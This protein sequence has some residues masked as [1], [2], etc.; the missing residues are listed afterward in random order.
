MIRIRFSVAVGIGAMLG[1]VASLSLATIAPNMS[2][3]AAP[4]RPGDP[5]PQCQPAPVD[6]S[7][8][9]PAPSATP[10]ILVNP[11][12]TQVAPRGGE[13]GLTLAWE[14]A[15]A[16]LPHIRGIHTQVQ[17]LGNDGRWYDVAGWQRALTNSNRVQWGF[18]ATDAGRGPFRWLVSDLITRQPLAI[19]KVFMLPNGGNADSEMVI[20]R[21]DSKPDAS[22]AVPRTLVTAQSAA[23]M[24]EPNAGVSHNGILAPGVGLT[25]LGV[26]PSGTWL[27]VR[28]DK[29][30]GWLRLSETRPQ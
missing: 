23:L 27:N 16:L 8:P 20:G 13:I 9:T 22:V 30:S 17:W 25:V 12:P 26:D 10:A 15:Q 6:A 7:T 4:C 1:L 21:D 24:V 18:A 29:K 28:V 11:T 14:N 5:R 2:D 19:G 3:A